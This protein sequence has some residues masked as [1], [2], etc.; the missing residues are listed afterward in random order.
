[1]AKKYRIKTN[2]KY[3]PK[4]IQFGLLLMTVFASAEY[5]WLLLLAIIKLFFLFGF[6][7]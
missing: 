5:K 7:C 1:M 2:K 3:S 6:M 4:E